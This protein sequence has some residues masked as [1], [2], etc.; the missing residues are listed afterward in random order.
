MWLIC[1]FFDNVIVFSAKVV[2]DRVSE[3]SK[4]Y[5]FVTFASQDEAEN[6]IAEMNEKV[7]IQIWNWC[8]TLFSVGT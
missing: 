6:A 4:G 2:T 3:K 1:G 8:D 5:G 7:I